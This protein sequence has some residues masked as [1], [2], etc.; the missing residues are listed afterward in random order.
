MNASEHPCEELQ[1]RAE[2]LEDEKVEHQKLL[3]A[4]QA[5]VAVKPFV[6]NSAEGCQWG[7]A[8]THNI[9]PKTIY[10]K[11]ICIQSENGDRGD[12]HPHKRHSHAT[13]SAIVAVGANGADTGGGPAGSPGVPVRRTR[14]NIHAEGKNDATQRV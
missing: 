9:L 10:S 12:K 8:S 5:R 2:K 4:R 6:P 1:R 3:R 7:L 13:R 11:L 14:T